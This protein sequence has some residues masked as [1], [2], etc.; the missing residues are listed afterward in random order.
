MLDLLNYPFFTRALVSCLL[1][2]IACGITGAYIVSKRIV[3]L[4]GSISHASFGGIGLGYY[5]GFNPI[6]GAGVFAVISALIAEKLSEKSKM[7]I[8][9]AIGLL[10]SFG[11]AIGIIFIFITP[12]YAPDL[13]SYL[14]GSILTISSLD[15]LAVAAVALIVA[16]SFFL[17][18]KEILY[19][20]FDS[21]YAKT[22]G[23]PVKGISY[24][25]MALSALTIVISIKAVGIILVIS[26]LT[27]PQAA[28]GLITKDFKRMIFLSIIFAL[29]ASIAGLFMSAYIDIPSGAAIIFTAAS[30]FIVTYCIKTI[31]SKKS[32]AKN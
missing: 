31:F 2:S 1:I 9:S 26:M 30:M 20:A 14:F 27:I 24:F 11:M 3:F 23:V 12:G 7:R 28:A 18:F 25:V 17:F 32:E 19:T 29:A 10:W 8:D 15:L 13:T 4:A 21:E 6:L 16:V 22:Q 5:F